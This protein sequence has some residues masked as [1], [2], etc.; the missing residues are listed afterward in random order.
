MV[1]TDVYIYICVY[2]HTHICIPHLI[3]ICIYAHTYIYIYTVKYY[4][5]I[6]KN[7]VTSF[8][9][10]WTDLEIIILVK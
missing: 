10:T 9:A 6:K 1:Y 5:A 3:C 8:A 2:T 7:D 4:S